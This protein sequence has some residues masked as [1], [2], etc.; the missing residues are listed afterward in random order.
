[1]E[2]HV[3]HYA[4]LLEDGRLEMGGPFLDAD[5]GGMMIATEGVGLDEL[6]RFAAEDPAV[7]SGLLRYEVRTWYVPMHN[8]RRSPAG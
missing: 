1:M 3:A 7:H 4:Q 2:A 8:R 5:A 6:E